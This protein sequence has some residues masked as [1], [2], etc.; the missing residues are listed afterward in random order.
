MLFK[1]KERGNILIRIN[2]HKKKDGTW[3]WAKVRA[4]FI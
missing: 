1:A 2:Y 3:F 4:N